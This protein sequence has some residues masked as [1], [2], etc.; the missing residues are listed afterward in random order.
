MRSLSLKSLVHVVA[1]SAATYTDS[2]LKIEYAKYPCGGSTAVCWSC[3]TGSNRYSTSDPRFQS[4]PDGPWNNTFGDFLSSVSE[5]N[6]Y[7]QSLP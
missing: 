3:T 7:W 6:R 4:D 5:A 1:V 2:S